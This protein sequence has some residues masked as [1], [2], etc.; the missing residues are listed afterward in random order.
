MGWSLVWLFCAEMALAVD[1]ALPFIAGADG[2][3]APEELSLGGQQ[4]LVLFIRGDSWLSL[5]QDLLGDW[6]ARG[7]FYTEIPAAYAKHFDDVAKNGAA[8]LWVYA[9]LLALALWA[10]MSGHRRPR[11]KKKN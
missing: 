1:R 10:S 7:V 9:P 3:V 4:P 2:T 8:P 11:L 5:V 6:D